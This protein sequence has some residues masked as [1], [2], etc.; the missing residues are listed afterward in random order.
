MLV[1]RVYW[2]HVAPYGRRAETMTVNSMRTDW[3]LFGLIL[4][5]RE[6]ERYA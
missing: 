6:E 4:I 2:H 3:L 5:F 1:K